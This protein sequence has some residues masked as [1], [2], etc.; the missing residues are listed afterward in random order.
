MELTHKHNDCFGPSHFDGS[1]QTGRVRQCVRHQHISGRWRN[2]LGGQSAGA[3][4]GLHG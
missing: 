3:A 4:A 2:I 1:G